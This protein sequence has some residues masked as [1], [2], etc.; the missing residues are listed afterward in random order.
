MLGKSTKKVIKATV[1]ISS[2]LILIAG[3]NQ[4]IDFSKLVP[5]VQ[6]VI[7][8][9]FTFTSLLLGGTMYNILNQE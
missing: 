9:L 5:E 6:I 7:L 4:L 1:L 3:L 8:C 2:W